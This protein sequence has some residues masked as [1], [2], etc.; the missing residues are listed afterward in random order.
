MFQIKPRIKLESGF[1]LIELLVVIGI[2]AVLLAITLVAINPAR[3][4]AK[5]ND[6]KR[7]NDVNTILN[8]IDQYAVDN[9]GNLP[10]TMPLPGASASAISNIGAN[11]CQYLTPTYVAALPSDPTAGIPTGQI[12]GSGATCEST[13]NTGYSVSVASGSAGRVTVTATGQILNPISVTR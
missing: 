9:S 12:T 5:A 1:T 7:L 2:L 4:F 6:T 8:A 11:L 13:Y 10:P 3:Q